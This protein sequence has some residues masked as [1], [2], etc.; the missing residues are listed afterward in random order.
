MYRILSG[1]PIYLKGDGKN[2]YQQGC[3][4]GQRKDPPGNLSAVG[5]ILKPS[6]HNKPGCGAGQ[7]K[8]QQHPP[9][10]LPVQKHGQ[11]PGNATLSWKPTGICWNRCLLTWFEIPWMHCKK[12]KHRKSNSRATVKATSMSA[13]RSVTMEKGP[14]H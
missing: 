2:G 4:P 8:G 7:Q 5:K 10:K 3:H 13:F 9:Q 12:Q 1:H 6:P 11:N 14:G